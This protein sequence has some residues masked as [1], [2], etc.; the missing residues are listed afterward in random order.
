MLDVLLSCEAAVLSLHVGSSRLMSNVSSS[1]APFDV[2]SASNHQSG[3][4]PNCL[5]ETCLKPCV[6]HLKGFYWHLMLE[7]DC[8]ALMSLKETERQLNIASNNQHGSPN[9][10]LIDRTKWA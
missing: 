10:N 4:R 7:P 8:P 1:S 5:L 6:R 2:T 9:I 3:I